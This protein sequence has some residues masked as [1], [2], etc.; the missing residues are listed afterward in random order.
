MV[1]LDPMKSLNP[2]LQINSKSSV[3]KST[4][5]LTIETKLLICGDKEEPLVFKLP[6]E[7]FKLTNSGF[8]TLPEK[9][10]QKPISDR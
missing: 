5:S 10:R 3:E 6:K 2:T 9:W 1:T 7:I 8:T 4:L